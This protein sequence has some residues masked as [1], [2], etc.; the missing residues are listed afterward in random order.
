MDALKSIERWVDSGMRLTAIE[1]PDPEHVTHLFRLYSR[2][3][4]KAVYLWSPDVGL[5]RLG[6]EFIPIPRTLRPADALEYILSSI[7]FGI[8]L[9]RDFPG[10]AQ[11]VRTGNLL[12]RIA[13]E[14]TR[15]PRNV[16][17]IGSAVN[18]APS[19]RPHLQHV[20]HVLPKAV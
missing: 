11:G 6:A 19:L 1:T 17:L 4:G 2:E 10:D 8:Y 13:S 9:L 12:R 15:V 18:I 7:H 14:T 3:T 5:F 16:F 20:R